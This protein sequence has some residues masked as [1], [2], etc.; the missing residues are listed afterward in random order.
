MGLEDLQGSVKHSQGGKGIKSRLINKFF[1][2]KPKLDH[3]SLMC[4]VSGKF[5]KNC[6]CFVFWGF[7]RSLCMET[8][9]KL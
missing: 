9:L 7:L 6:S 5:W 3:L 8:N 1:V 2:G 4:S